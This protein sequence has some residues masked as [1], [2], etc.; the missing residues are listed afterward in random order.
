VDELASYSNESYHEH[1]HINSVKHGSGPIKPTDW[2]V[3]LEHGRYPGLEL[4]ALA[5]PS[6][7]RYAHS[8]WLES[9]VNFCKK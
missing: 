2:Y 5:W 3:G 1:V 9:L 4:H 6:Q 7:K 8:R